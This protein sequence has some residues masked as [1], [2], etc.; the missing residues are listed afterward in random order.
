MIISVCP[1]IHPA[2]VQKIIERTADKVDRYRKEN[3]DPDSEAFST[4]IV[5]A[6]IVDNLKVLN[7]KVTNTKEGVGLDYAHLRMDITNDPQV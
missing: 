5:P 7:E 4:L 1:N 3:K 6:K 2:E